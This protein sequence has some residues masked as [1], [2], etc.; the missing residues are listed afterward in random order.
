ML[1]LTPFSNLK[2][3]LPVMDDFA[4]TWL[5]E[6]DKSAATLTS[7]KT[8]PSRL[9]IVPFRVNVLSGIS[10]LLR[11]IT[12]PSVSVTSVSPL[13]ETVWLNCVFSWSVYPIYSIISVN[14]SKSTIVSFPSPFE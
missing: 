1:A 8:A 7:D 5:V 14:D 10:V 13:F 6:L 3:K 9:K 2:L 12:A 11:V 4:T